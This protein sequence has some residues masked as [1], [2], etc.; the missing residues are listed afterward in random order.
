MWSYWCGAGPIVRSRFNLELRPV[1]MEPA[2]EGV[3]DECL[4]LVR[5]LCCDA[6]LALPSVV[7][8]LIRGDTPAWCH[9]ATDNNLIIQYIYIY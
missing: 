7:E 6:G 5:L 4:D 2:E 9:D 8:P 1:T 3:C